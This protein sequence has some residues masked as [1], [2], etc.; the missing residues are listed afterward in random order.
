M[1]L[2]FDYYRRQKK[3]WLSDIQHTNKNENETSGVIQERQRSE[4]YDEEA[5]RSGKTAA[6]KNTQRIKVNNITLS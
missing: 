2:T 3:S 4:G 1:C 5:Q 6:N